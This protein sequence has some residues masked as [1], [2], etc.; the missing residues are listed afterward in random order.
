MYIIY[1]HTYVL[2]IYTFL[3]IYKYKY[4]YPILPWCVWPCLVYNQKNWQAKRAQKIESRLTKHLLNTNVRNMYY[5]KTNTYSLGNQYKWPLTKYPTANEV[6]NIEH[7][8]VLDIQQPRRYEQEP[9][10]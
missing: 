3:R 5:A 8:V 2:Y 4:E 6:I 9:I 7:G 10:S 1:V